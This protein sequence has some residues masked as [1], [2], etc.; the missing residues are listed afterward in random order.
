MNDIDKEQIATICRDILAPM[1]ASD[2][3]HFYL[4]RIDGDDVHIHLAGTCAG[5]PGASLTGDK[6]ILPALRTACPS[7]RLVLT[8]GARV[9]DGAQKL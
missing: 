9:P 4:V 6:I 3:G 7:V 5:C 2:A 8:T 1:V